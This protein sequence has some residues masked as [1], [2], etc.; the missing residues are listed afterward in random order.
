MSLIYGDNLPP[1]GRWG[2]VLVAGRDAVL[3]VAYCVGR[4]KHYELQTDVKL[5]TWL[6]NIVISVENNVTDADRCS[7]IIILH[8][9]DIIDML[10]HLVAVQQDKF[11]VWISDAHGKPVNRLNEHFRLTGLSINRTETDNMAAALSLNFVYTFVQ[12]KSKCTM[13]TSSLNSV[14][15]KFETFMKR[16][17]RQRPSLIKSITWRT[18]DVTSKATV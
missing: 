13:Y 3:E 16:K 4:L 14:Y 12:L 5:L 17:N 2:V 15:W 11:C 18:S 7:D 8:S 9:N 10:S 1:V 6:L